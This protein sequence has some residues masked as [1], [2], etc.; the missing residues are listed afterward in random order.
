MRTTLLFVLP[1][2]SLAGAFAQSDSG[3]TFKA[4]VTVIQVPVVVRDHDGNVVSNLGK[5]DFQLFDNGK[6]QD[7]ASFAVET[8]GSQAAPDRSLAD[9]N[10]PSGQ[11]AGGTG[12]AIPERFVGYLFDDVTIRDT[13]DLTR[14][15]DAAAR[16]I[17][18]LEPGDRAA[19]YTASCS[20]GTDFTA[21]RTKLQET[22]A[23]L[24][25]RAV[26]VCRVSRMQVL[27]V[28]LL[29]ALVKKMS[30][31]PGRRDIVFVSSG[32]FVGPDRSKDEADLIDA[33]VRAKVSINAVDVGESAAFAT[34]NDAASRNPNSG[35]ALNAYPSNPLVLVELAH[36]TGGTYVSGNDFNVSFHKLATPE[37]HYVL[38]FIPNGKADG[39]VHQLKVKLENSHKLTVEARAEYFAQKSSE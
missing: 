16:Q 18:A 8:P 5:D 13:G 30:N 22:V 12:L 17:G 11:P 6:R 23:R 34:G 14:I 25:F 4:G 28:E 15:R 39:R 36:G 9:P 3:E 24:Q 26:Q 37:S 33:A 32:F 29:K 1:L 7:I 19:V 31:L 35:R 20:V 21:D 2:I 10:A 27:Q 38:G